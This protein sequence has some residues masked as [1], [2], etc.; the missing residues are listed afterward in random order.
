MSDRP[1][2]S[3]MVF[4]YNQEDFIRDA[5]KGALEQTYEPMEL[6]FSDDCSEDRTFEIIKKEAEAYRGPHK[7][8]LNRNEKNMGIAIHTNCVFEMAKGDFFVTAAGDDISVPERTELL[9]KRWQDRTSPVDLV[10]SYYEEVDINANPTGFIE[11]NVVFV[12][13]KSLHVRQWQCGATGACA[14]YS[15]KLFDKYGPL[16][17]NIIAED[18]VFSFRAWI[19]SGIACIEM[20]LVKHR[21]HDASISVIHKNVRKV[22]SLKTRKS[23]MR[24]ASRGKLGRAKEWLKAWTRKHHQA[25]DPVATQLRQWIE[26][27]KLESSGYDSSRIQAL[28]FVFKS[29]FLAGGSKTAAKIFIRHVL[30][31]Y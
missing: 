23:I 18:W 10:C 27:L 1:L 8:V 14:A 16:D 3:Y 26:L 19:E 20:P 4:S 25:N 5:I 12:P 15:R 21:T 11:K 13:D 28:K 17:P 31:Y 29:L 6:I 9:V 24:E 30:R 2:V 22:S 7:I